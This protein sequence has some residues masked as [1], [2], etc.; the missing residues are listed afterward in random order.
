MHEQLRT[1][2]SQKGCLVPFCPLIFTGFDSKMAKEISLN[3]RTG[4]LGAPCCKRDKHEEKDN[5]EHPEQTQLGGEGRLGPGHYSQPEST[6]I[7]GAKYCRPE[8]H[9]TPWVP[10]PRQAGPIIALRWKYDGI[11]LAIS[12]LVERTG[13]SRSTFPWIWN[14]TAARDSRVTQE[15]ISHHGK[16]DDDGLMG[17]EFATLS[18]HTNSRVDQCAAGRSNLGG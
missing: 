5:S 3:L 14:T 17:W 15:Q 8:T 2:P 4:C 13:S 9:Y 11:M 16:E 10:C 12:W 6:G 1:H 18:A 7:S